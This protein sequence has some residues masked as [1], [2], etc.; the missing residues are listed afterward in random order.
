[1][2][3]RRDG[4]VLVR[5]LDVESGSEKLI[6]PVADKSSLGRAAAAAADEDKSR[7]VT[8]EGRTWF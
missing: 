5:A 6:D 7:H 2:A 4:R 8:I 1:M 3:A